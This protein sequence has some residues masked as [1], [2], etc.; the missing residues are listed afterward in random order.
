[1][2]AEFIVERD[3]AFLELSAATDD[4]WQDIQKIAPIFQDVSSAE[5]LED[6]DDEKR[7]KY[8]TALFEGV[9]EPLLTVPLLLLHKKLILSLASRFG[10]VMMKEDAIYEVITEI[11]DDFLSPLSLRINAKYDSER[12]YITRMNRKVKAR[13][14]SYDK[15]NTDAHENYTQIVLSVRK[16]SWREEPSTALHNTFLMKALQE[17]MSERDYSALLV[18]AGVKEAHEEEFASDQMRNRREREAV[19]TAKKI[20]RSIDPSLNLKR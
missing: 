7:K 1:M 5:E 2:G 16:D 10:A 6:C 19:E 12:G 14:R 4:S 13:V 3:A 17:T 15:H 18:R 8:H 11:I 9:R 20:L